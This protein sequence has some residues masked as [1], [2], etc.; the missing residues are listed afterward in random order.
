MKIIK[1]KA[2]EENSNRVLLTRK[3]QDIN[4]YIHD[5]K[6]LAYV[7]ERLDQK[8]EMVLLNQ[9]DHQVIVRILD[10]VDT[11][12]TSRLESARKA[13][14]GIHTTL[15]DHDMGMVVV[16]NCGVEPEECVAF[17]EG[18]ALT[19]YQ[20]LKYYTSEPDKKYKLG[21]IHLFDDGLTNDHVKK[22]DNLVR[23]VY[24]TR[25][26]VNEPLSY[27]TAVQLSVEIEKMGKEAGF[28]VEV[29]N[30]KKIE[31][32]KMGGLLAV[33]KG[34]VDPPTFSILTWKP[35][36]AVNSCPIILVGKG[37]VFDSGGLSLKPTLDSMDYMKCDM[38]GAAAVAGAFYSV[39]KNNLPVW[40][41]GLIPATDNRP[42]GN[43]YVPGDVVTMYD[44]TT[45]EVLNTDAEGR[46]LLADALSYAKQ[47]D[48]EVVIELSTLTG[49]AHI[50]IDKYGIVG[51]GNASREVMDNLK[52]SGE[53]TSERIAEFPFWDEYKEQ[54]K[55]EIADLKN[56]G[57]K[58]AGAI[59]AGKFLEHF[60]DYPYIHLDIAGPSFNKV[61]FNYRGIGGS[62]VGVRILYNYLLNRSL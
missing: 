26:L 57:S 9:L 7:H 31:S 6:Q 46:M 18:L 24:H 17:A 32:L 14:F 20:F 8:K 29:F 25:D 45:V 5:K 30:K 34:S 40:V 59:T 16:V 62:G 3:G 11:P 56:I 55:S 53:Y 35:D 52:E 10:G 47:Y 21:E 22:L 33:N 36:R 13:G 19:N 60:T 23:G 12:K 1:I 2:L 43:A 50:A 41:I 39:A 58:Y 44:G 37:V 49:S 15:N 42:D 48:P 51:M 61:P 54:L 4:A 28:S 38:G 27:L